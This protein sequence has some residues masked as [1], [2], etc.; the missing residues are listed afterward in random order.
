[1]CQNIDEVDALVEAAMAKL[2]RAQKLIKEKKSKIKEK[3]E[4]L[5]EKSNINQG[6]FSTIYNI[7]SHYQ[8]Y[9]PKA[10]RSVKK[11]SSIYR[12]I[13]T[14]L[15]EGYTYEEICRAIDGQHMSPFHLG[16]NRHKTEYLQL[17]LVVRSGEKLDMFI[18][19]FDRPKTSTL[20]PK[21]ARTLTAA[22][23]WLSDDE[24]LPDMQRDQG[25][26]SVSPEPLAAGWVA[27]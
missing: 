22:Q 3:K 13:E 26:S 14:R 9:H 1:M 27:K 5:K 17:E 8:K 2:L 25:S 19:I 11:N 12:K 4:C 6:T 24:D 21:T 16:D 15:L 7:I 18:A 20:K 10:M 23:D